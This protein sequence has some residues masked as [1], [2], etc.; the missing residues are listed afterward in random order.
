MGQADTIMGLG[1]SEHKNPNA[2]VY[3][4]QEEHSGD[5]TCIPRAQG[6]AP[7]R[8]ESTYALI[9]FFNEVFGTPSHG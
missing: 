1:P 7:L 9:Q 2:M 8:G 6:D 4:S 3:Q 5:G